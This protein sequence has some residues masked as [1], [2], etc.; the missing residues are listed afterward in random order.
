MII[1]KLGLVGVVLLAA[2]CAEIGSW[3]EKKWETGSGTWE[4][5]SV[6]WEEWGRDRAECRTLARQEAERDFAIARQGGPANDYSRLAPVT[7]QMDRFSAQQREEEV[8]ERCLRDRGYRRVQ[9][10]GTSR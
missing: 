7:T 5:P 6:P 1:G 2:A 3:W 9:R 4:H 10:T 8:Y